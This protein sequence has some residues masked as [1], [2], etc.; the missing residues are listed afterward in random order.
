MRALTVEKENLERTLNR[1][2][3]D[4][5]D[6]GVDAVGKAKR[7]FICGLYTA[8]LL[9]ELFA[10]QLRLI[11]LPALSV[12]G[13]PVRMAIE[14]RDVGPG[15]VVIAIGFSGLSGQVAAILAHARERGAKTIALS[16]SDMTPVARAA[17]VVLVCAAGSPVHM[18]SETTV[19]AVVLSIFQALAASRE[20]ILRKNLA[21]LETAYKVVVAERA[22][23]VGTIEETVL[24]VY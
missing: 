21:D 18:P 14:L 12:S 3:S 6:Q 16:G 10:S 23:S 17:D 9:A 7:I 20:D 4:M 8:R 5:A 11:G 2:S 24:K 22:V 19:A 15:D 13:D 1:I